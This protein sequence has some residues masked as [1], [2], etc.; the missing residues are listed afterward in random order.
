M[1]DK[2]PDCPEKTTEVYVC[3]IV[4]RMDNRCSEVVYH[5]CYINVHFSVIDTG[6]II[7]KC[8]KSINV[9]HLDLSIHYLS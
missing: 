9:A 3:L 2:K 8:L 5:I 4:P 7:T 1:Y 6:A